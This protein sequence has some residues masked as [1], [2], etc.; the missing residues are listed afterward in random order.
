MRV[1]FVAGPT[2]DSWYSMV[3]L[4]QA[5]RLAGHEV[6]VAGHADVLPAIVGA[7]LAG[8]A[9][10]TATLRDCLVDRR[11]EDATPPADGLDRD[12]AVGRVYGRHAAAGLDE[13]TK[14][15][16]DWRPDRVVGDALALAAPLAAARHEIAFTR[17]G[18]DVADPVAYTLAAITEL[19]PELE[20]L[21]RYEMPPLRSSVTVAPP[22]LR[23]ADAPPSMPL[24]YI[25]YEGPVRAEAWMYERGDRPRIVV[26]VHAESLPWALSGPSRLLEL[27]A[28]LDELDAEIV[29]AVPPGVTAEN[30]EPLPAGA[31]AARAPLAVLAGG[32][33]LVIHHGY[34][35]NVLTCFD[36]GVPQLVLPAH[37]GFAGHA[38]RVAELG[39][40]R[41]LRAADGTAEQ[42]T[43]LAREVLGDP[44]LREAARR[45]ATEMHD[46]P[47]PDR[48]AVDLA[49]PV[50][51]EVTA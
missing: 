34:A 18:T 7:G 5:V 36:G 12:V 43:E 35:D 20:R 50:R 28:G 19:G 6:F 16:G 25:P 48:I 37:P 26:G 8:V 47:E 33:D 30:L 2:A 4:A 3:P 17:F 40:G 9:V 24:R 21:G 27:T 31:R 32:A 1:L 49:V 22:G 46:M 23:P 41:V 11:G 15:V 44:G 39:A 29:V 13:L 38:E 10:S 42:V 14:F 45:I 51:D